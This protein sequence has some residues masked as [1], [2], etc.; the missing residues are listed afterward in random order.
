MT[1]DD[2]RQRVERFYE[3]FDKGNI[4]T[5]V[6]AFSSDLEVIDPGI[7]RVRGVAS[8]RAYLESFK[9]A[10]PDGR[11]I[12][13]RLDAHE[14][15]VVVEG[16]FVGS[17]TGPISGPDG[18]IKPTGA[19]VN[20]RFVNLWGLE[21]GIISSHHAYYDQLDLLTQLGLMKDT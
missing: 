18:D 20:V 19:S 13:D 4:A 7:G 11:I 6:S 5:A 2:A 3:E 12:V 21:G 16:Q 17:H 15:A 1:R 14:D 10:M 8:F 9:L